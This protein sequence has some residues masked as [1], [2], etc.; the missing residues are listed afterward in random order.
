VSGPT[1]HVAFQA[2]AAGHLKHR[3]RLLACAVVRRR[4]RVRL[5]RRDRGS[6]GGVLGSGGLVEWDRDRVVR[7]RMPGGVLRV[8]RGADAPERAAEGRGC[9][10][11]C[12]SGWSYL[13]GAKHRAPAGRPCDIAVAGRGSGAPIPVGATPSGERAAPSRWVTGFGLRAHRSL[14]RSVDRRNPGRLGARD[15]RARPVSSHQP[16]VPARATAAA[17]RRRSRRGA[18]RGVDGNRADHP[19]PSPARF[20]L[21][22]WVIMSGSRTGSPRGSIFRMKLL[23][24]SW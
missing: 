19:D 17:G 5:V 14:R 6:R 16:T 20:A 3:R 4:A 10:Q 11:H 2:S 21:P 22:T 15:R 18:R 1:L 7:P 12:G 9:Q 13:G 24:R 23:T 8:P